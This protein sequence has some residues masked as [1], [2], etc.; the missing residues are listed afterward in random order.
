MVL[1]TGEL[2]YPHTVKSEFQIVTPLYSLSEGC[3][4]QSTQTPCR[5]ISLSLW[6]NLSLALVSVLKSLRYD[7]FLESCLSW[8]M[9][10]RD[11]KEKEVYYN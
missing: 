9:W 6:P 4:T 11:M 1:H 7:P 2:Q 10:G 8:I 3:L 5:H